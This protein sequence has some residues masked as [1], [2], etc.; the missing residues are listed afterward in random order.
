MKE[1]DLKNYLN[2]ISTEGF[3][4]LQNGNMVLALKKFVD[5]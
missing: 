2:K 3:S 1:N 4:A 5:K